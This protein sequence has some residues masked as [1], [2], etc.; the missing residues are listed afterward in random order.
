MRSNRKGKNAGGGRCGFTR[1]CE[2]YKDEKWHYDNTLGHNVFVYLLCISVGRKICMF[3]FQYIYFYLVAKAA[4]RMSVSTFA[5]EIGN[6]VSSCSGLKPLL[7]FEYK[8][9]KN[10]CKMRTFCLQSTH[11]F[12]RQ[13][14][15]YSLLLH[16][17][18]CI[19]RHAR[20]SRKLAC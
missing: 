16:N 7:T 8:L 11:V 19:P 10:L 6:R 17:D 3:Y 20:Q 14:P 4:R 13:L 2:K 9:H 1:S 5:A 12:E 18:S 15:Q